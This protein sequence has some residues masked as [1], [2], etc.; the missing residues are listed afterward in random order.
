MK[1]VKSDA[2]IRLSES[3]LSPE[4]KSEDCDHHENL[5]LT[6][7]IPDRIDFSS[8]QSESEQSLRIV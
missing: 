7:T 3:S 1:Y 5:I 8:F 6:E 4:I 2:S